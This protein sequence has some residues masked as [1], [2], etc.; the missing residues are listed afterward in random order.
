MQ[1]CT[2]YEADWSKKRKKEKTPHNIYVPA[3]IEISLNPLREYSVQLT[4]I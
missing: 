3:F 4:F 2:S 1:V